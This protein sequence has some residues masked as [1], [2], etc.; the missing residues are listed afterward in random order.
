[1][2]PF[3]AS[4]AAER[5]GEGS[6]LANTLVSAQMLHWRMQNYSW[7]TIDVLPH[8]LN[9][10]NPNLETQAEL[11]MG[12]HPKAM[13]EVEFATG[14]ALGLDEWVNSDPQGTIGLASFNRFGGK[15][16]YLMKLLSAAQP[17]SIQ[18]HPDKKQAE[19]G[20]AREN[21]QGIDIGAK[22][23]NYRDDNHKPELICAVT[24]FAAMV[25]F[26]P[27]Y[28]AAKLL[29]QLG[30]DMM[31]PWYAL[32]EDQRERIN[33]LMAFF[34]FLLN[35]TKQQARA[36]I[37][38]SVVNARANKCPEFVEF[39]KLAKIN[40]DD[41]GVFA[42]IYL[43]LV[44][45]NPG[46][47]L[48]L[49]PGVMHAYLRGTGIEIMAC[50]DNVLRC[51]LTHK[52]MDRDELICVANFNQ[53][54]VEVLK[55]EQTQYKGCSQFKV[56]IEDFVLQRFEVADEISDRY[57]VFGLEIGFVTEGNVTVST[58]DGEPQTF[59][60]GESFVLPAASDYFWL[61]GKGTV[62]IGKT[63]LSHY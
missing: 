33:P 2:T 37:K 6:P 1:M 13:S 36:L 30:I 25:G 16:P 24:P 50:S 47:A 32:N 39:I 9:V 57:P 48:Y 60:V 56:P 63:N 3:F 49:P 41:V 54:Q 19:Q 31:A 59:G 52:H 18:V 8:L 28:D 42:P 20:F 12:A 23:R 21:A 5:L 62:F 45:L 7:G 26:R 51:G 22:H 14:E 38:E 53:F 4:T 61:Q 43:N 58:I 27:Q 10:P 35:M 55:P 46:E 29:L 34:M 11:W 44:Y 15:V 17:L 40:P